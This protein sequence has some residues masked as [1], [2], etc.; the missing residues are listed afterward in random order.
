MGC[1]PN[2]HWHKVAGSSLR[3]SHR[4]KAGFPPSVIIDHMLIWELVCMA[5]LN[6]HSTP[7][8]SGD[9]DEAGTT[10][11]LMQNEMLQ[12]VS[13]K[14][15]P[16]IQTQIFDILTTSQLG[17]LNPGTQGL[18]AYCAHKYF[19]KSISNHLLGPPP[20]RPTCSQ[21]HLPNASEVLQAKEERG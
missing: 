8:R 12:L 4:Y 20:P 21:T 17:L 14:R 1:S 6:Y 10:A 11:S 19:P 3:G 18:G 2:C 5:P 15:L 16:S 9:S 13:F 7:G